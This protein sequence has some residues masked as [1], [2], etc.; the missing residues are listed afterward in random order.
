MEGIATCAGD[1]LSILRGTPA[2]MEQM[3]GKLSAFDEEDATSKLATAFEHI[4]LRRTSKQTR[5]V[6]SL[7]EGGNNPGARHDG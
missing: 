5:G 2:M 4:A 1:V 6:Q 3:L 7:H